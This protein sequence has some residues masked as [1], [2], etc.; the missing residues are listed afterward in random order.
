M[1]VAVLSD[2]AHGRSRVGAQDARRLVEGERRRTGERHG[3]ADMAAACEDLR[4]HLGDVLHVDEGLSR[5][6]DR[7]ED[8][9][10][11]RHPHPVVVRGLSKRYGP[12]TVVDSVSFTL[13]AGTITGFL[14]PNG[15]GKST[16]LRLLLGLARPTAGE[17]MIFGH[18][19]TQLEQP[20]RQVSAVLESGDF[21]P[22]RSGRN[23]LRVLALAAGISGQ[24]VEE[25][26][27]LVELAEAAGRSVRPYLFAGDA[28]TARARGCTARRPTAADS[29]RAGKRP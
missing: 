12:A 11:D 1:R 4:G 13:P 25:V 27:G 24:Q 26:L 29:R 22:G 23:H 28:S 15:A 16:T 19:Y 18:R 14:G 20:A 3:L 21:D 9:A 2:V 10:V 5:V 17:A 6:A 7:S 8:L